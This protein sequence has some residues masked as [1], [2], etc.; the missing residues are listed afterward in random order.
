[1]ICLQCSKKQIKT[2]NVCKHI[3]L[4]HKAII[5]LLRNV[6]STISCPFLRVSIV[7]YSGAHRVFIHNKKDKKTKKVKNKKDKKP[8]KAK[9]LKKKKDKDKKDKRQKKEHNKKDKKKDDTKDKKDKKNYKK[10]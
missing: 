1:M 3:M 4:I 5:T 9:K 10:Q 8:K 7:F 6:Y 2:L